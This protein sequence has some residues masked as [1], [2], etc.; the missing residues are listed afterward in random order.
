VASSSSCIDACTATGCSPS[1]AFLDVS[2]SLF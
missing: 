1:G 2:L